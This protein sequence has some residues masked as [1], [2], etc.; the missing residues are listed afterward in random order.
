MTRSTLS[1]P[2]GLSSSYFKLEPRGISMT[3]WKSRGTSL[4][5]ETSCQGCTISVA[6]RSEELN[7]HYRARERRNQ[8][9]SPGPRGAV[10]N[11]LQQG[12]AGGRSMCVE[13]EA[14][15]WC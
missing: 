12:G 11:L 1:R 13:S 10:F 9:P 4:P 7:H 8:E 2:V 5:G 15:P 6:S 14:P 3:A